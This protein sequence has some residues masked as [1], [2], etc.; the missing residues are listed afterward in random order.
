MSNAPIDPLAIMAEHRD[1]HDVHYIDDLAWDC[2]ACML[3]EFGN[4][5]CLPYRL[6][7]EVL[8]LRNL[9]VTE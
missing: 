6:A 2:C 9:E 4:R 3:P 5:S 8:R 7:S 1:H